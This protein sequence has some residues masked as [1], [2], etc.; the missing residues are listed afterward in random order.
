MPELRFALW[1]VCWLVVTKIEGL[2]GVPV[3]L[4]ALGALVH[5]GTVAA[6]IEAAIYREAEH[7]S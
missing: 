3:W 4:N 5:V 7:K 2:A 1:I 6:L